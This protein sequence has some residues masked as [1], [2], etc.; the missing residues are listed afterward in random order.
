[1]RAR[2]ERSYMLGR[3]AAEWEKT[4]L[5][6]LIALSCSASTRSV[7]CCVGGSESGCR[8]T[9]WDESKL[10]QM[11]RDGCR[12]WRIRESG[13]KVCSVQCAVWQCGSVAVCNVQ[14]V[15]EGTC[16]MSSVCLCLS[17]AALEFPQIRWPSLDSS[18]SYLS[19]RQ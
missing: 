6:L 18:R 1:V 3:E 9:G 17:R 19:F 7:R 5:N 13:G 15:G 16:H 8:Q 10:V 4:T 11:N 12:S 2:G 14:T